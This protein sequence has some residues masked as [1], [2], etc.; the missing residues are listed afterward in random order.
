[1]H[2]KERR[3]NKREKKKRNKFFPFRKYRE[4]L[5]PEE[6]RVEKNVIMGF[7]FGWLVANLIIVVALLFLFFEPLIGQEISDFVVDISFKVVANSWENSE[8]VNSLAYLCSLNEKEYQKVN[9]VYDFIYS[10]LVIG[11]H[12]EGSNKLNRPEEMFNSPSVCRDTA[13]LFMSTMNKLNI[14]NDLIHEPG[15]VYNIVYL[16][17]FDCYIDVVNDGYS[18]EKKSNETIKRF[19]YY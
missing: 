2:D 19:K 16:D 7:L 12:D 17:K 11:Y 14:E 18:C 8:V 15:H 1:M 10:N 13:T 4:A 5:T 9:C 6:K 3:S